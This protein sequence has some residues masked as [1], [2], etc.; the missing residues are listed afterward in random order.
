MKAVRGNA[1]FGP[2][3]HRYSTYRSW[4]TPEIHLVSLGFRVIKRTTNPYRV[5]RGGAWNNVADYCRSAYRDYRLP[6][7]RSNYL[8]FRVMKRT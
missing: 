7:N 8:G 6:S 2:K 5:I 3:E 1:W 4:D